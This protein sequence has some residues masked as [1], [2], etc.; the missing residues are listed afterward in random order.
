MVT[1]FLAVATLLGQVIFHRRLLCP[2]SPASPFHRQAVSNI[3][4]IAHK[5]YNSDPRTLRRLQWPLL[6][7]LI[8]TDD[9]GQRAWIRKRLYELRDFHSEYVWVNQVADE[10][11]SHQDAERGQNVNLAEVLRRQHVRSSMI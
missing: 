3:I 1:A 10:V 4:D 6:M 8:E 2:G 5:Q 11:L 7:A 9:T